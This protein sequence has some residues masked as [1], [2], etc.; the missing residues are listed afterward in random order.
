[1]P[2]PIKATI[3]LGALQH[4]LAIV[5]RR[6][7]GASVFAVAKADAYGH[8]VMR[9]LRRLNPDVVLRT[10]GSL[11]KSASTH[12]KQPAA[13]VAVAVA[14]A[15]AEEAGPAARYEPATRVAVTTAR[16]DPESV[17]VRVVMRCPVDD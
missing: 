7:P 13:T 15:L 1:M 16:R 6:A 2:R 8:G 9:A 11:S 3:D 14:G 10:P 17:C 12:Q 5:R 4:N